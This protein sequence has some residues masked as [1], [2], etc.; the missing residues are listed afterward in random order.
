MNRAQW[1]KV[2]SWVGFKLSVLLSFTLV[3]GTLAVLSHELDW[4]TNPAMRVDSDTVKTMEWT[5]I[6]QSAITQQP[7]KH[8]LHIR[9]P[10]NP[11]FAAEVVFFSQDKIRHRMF[12]HPTTSEYLG[13]GRWYNWQRF[14]RMSHRHLMV[15]TKVGV[16]I[17]GALGFL[18]AIALI[19]SLVV[20]RK[21]WT[22]FFRMPRRSHRKLFWADVHRLAGVWSI[23]FIAVIA[24][25][26][27]WYFAEVWGL[28]AQYPDRGKALSE[29]ALD[30]KV[31]PTVA[32]FSEMMAS[33]KTLYPELAVERVFFPQR[34]GNGVQLQGQGK[35]LLVRA[36]ANMLSFDPISGALLAKNKGEDLSIHARISEAADPLHF[37]TFAGLPS[38]LVYFVFGILLSTLAITGTYIYGMRI[39][40]VGKHE[41]KVRRQFWLAATRTMTW[42]KW[43]SLTA[44]TICL[45]ITVLLFGGFVSE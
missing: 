11:W 6:Y 40:K 32:V 25:T 19:T 34:N 36:R 1:F 15:P 24:I 4:L 31:L 22:G 26:G 23:W 13:D 28:R 45:V 10:I 2:H 7:N 38:K 27:I 16:T 44:I 12:F 42:G 41:P 17:V 8:L 33:A 14:L 30:A 37:G 39:A 35:A 21:W 29:Q 20:Y 9:A 5:R 18:L 3:T 43:F